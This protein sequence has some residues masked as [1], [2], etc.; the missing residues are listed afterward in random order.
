M[1]LSPMDTGLLEDT[2]LFKGDFDLFSDKRGVIRFVAAVALLLLLSISSYPAFAQWQAQSVEPGGVYSACDFCLASQGISPLEAGASG[3]RVDLRYL[4]VGT[5][6]LNG[7]KADNEHQELET[8]LTQQYSLLLSLSPRL[9]L[10]AI[11]PVAKRYSEESEE[12]GR[13]ATGRQFGLADISVLARY[14]LLVAHDM[15]RTT[16][17][18]LNAGVKAPTG[19]TNGRDNQGNLLDAHVQLGTGS[20]D[21][22]TGGSVMMAWEKFALILNVLGALTTE[23][24]NG[25]R[26]GNMLNYE[27]VA[28]YRIMPDD[29]EGTFVFASLGINGEWRAREVQDGSPVDDSG[30]NVTYISPGLQIMFTPEFSLEAAYQFPVLHAL[31]GRQLG[32]DYRIMTGLQIL[33]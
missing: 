24:A 2:S 10:S 19:R 17:L 13:L 1:A 16:I 9:T 14:K 15:E 25:H 30:G 11:V 20:T 21:F 28:R 22:L 12:D 18:S 26:F 31:H 29:Y 8:H 7:S 32:E 33:F 27:G 3:I 5:I 4:H 6:Y 23:G